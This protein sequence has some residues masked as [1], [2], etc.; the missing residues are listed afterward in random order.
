MATC[1]EKLIDQIEQAMQSTGSSP[2]KADDD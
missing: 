1:P 2:P